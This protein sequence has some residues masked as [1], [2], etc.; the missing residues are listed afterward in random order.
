M[1]VTKEALTEP[2]GRLKIN[3]L[4]P[5]QTITVDRIPDVAEAM[6]RLGTLR[7]NA[8]RRPSFPWT[9]FNPDD[10]DGQR[11]ID[12]WLAQLAEII[13]I[14]DTTSNKSGAFARPA[15]EE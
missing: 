2:T 15:G 4:I 6:A 12:L 1:N 3:R 8:E 11:T 10:L 5:P 14:T 7:Q 13:L 9:P